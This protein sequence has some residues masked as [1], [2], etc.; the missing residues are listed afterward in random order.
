M[1]KMIQKPMA[2][3]SPTNIK[4]YFSRYILEVKKLSSSSE[5]NYQRGLKKVSR[6]MRDLGLVEDSIYEI[7]TIEELDLAWQTLKEDPEFSTM[8]KTGHRMYS[9]GFSCYRKFA[10]GELFRKYSSIDVQ[11]LDLPMKLEK[12]IKVEYKIWK[13]SGIMRTQTVAMAD[14]KCNIDRGHTTFIAERTGK[15]YM[16]AHHIIPLQLQEKFSSSLDVYANLMALC[17]I[18]HRKLHLGIMEER[19]LMIDSIYENR[20]ERLKKCGFILG[21]EEFEDLILGV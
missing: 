5:Y 1:Q 14:Y 15:P 16:E 10:T 19:R 6:G 3:S 18:C 13:R 12:P 21:K 4:E 8:D 2:I 9:S 20:K 7:G 11:T 17:P